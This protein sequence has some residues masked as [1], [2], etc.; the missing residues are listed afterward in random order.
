MSAPK[1]FSEARTAL[2]EGGSVRS[3]T[4]AALASAEAH[5]DLNAFLELFPDTA[6]AQAARVDAAFSA[7]SSG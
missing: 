6:L 7:G 2:A 5:K 1:T 3:A 4:E